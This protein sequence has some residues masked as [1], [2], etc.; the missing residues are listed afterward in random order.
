M[1]NSGTGA[2]LLIGLLATHPFTSFLTGDASLCGRPM[3]RVL[4][5]L[6]GFGAA[7][8]CRSRGRLPAAVVGAVD[9]VPVAYRTPVASAQ[10]K[11]AVL[12]A[13]LN[14]PGPYDGDRGPAD[15]R[16]YRADA[17]PFRR[18]G[19]RRGRSRRGADRLGPRPARIGR[20]RCR[21]P[22]RHLV[23]RLRHR[24]RPAGARLEGHDSRRRPQSA[25]HRPARGP[26]R[27]GGPRSP[28]R[29]RERPLANRSATSPSRR[30]RCVAPTSR[31]NWRRR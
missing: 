7:F 26:G 29:T 4:D 30:G 15:P 20:P 13:G 14:T 16:P 11:S 9:P 25:A 19:K 12:L 24:R 21:G 1:G 5:P 2:R 28:S 3:R 31:P 27:N 10:V 22:G 17:A 8:H 6:E 18:R 23:G